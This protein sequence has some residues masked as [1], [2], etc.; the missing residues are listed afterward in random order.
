[1]LV[2]LQVQDLECLVEIKGSHVPFVSDAVLITTNMS[3]YKMVQGVEEEHIAAFKRRLSKYLYHFTSS[4]QRHDYMKW[5]GNV[6]AEIYSTPKLKCYSPY[7]DEYYAVV[8][9]EED[10]NN[11]PTIS[12]DSELSEDDRDTVKESYPFDETD[13]ITAD[14]DMLLEERHPELCCTQQQELIGHL[15]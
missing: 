14:E 8:A 15:S 11:C 2:K 9:A 10:L 13:Q 6:L 12:E 5:L 4:D 3:L 1:M 7:S